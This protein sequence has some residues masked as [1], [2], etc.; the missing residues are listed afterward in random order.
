[1]QRGNRILG[2][3]QGGNIERGYLVGCL[4]GHTLHFGYSQQERGGGIHGGSSICFLE[5]L[6]DGRL[7]IREHFTWKTR[8]GAGM[9]IFDQD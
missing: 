7:R 5:L 2:R 1:M 3:Y 6:S 8:E 4:A 9:N